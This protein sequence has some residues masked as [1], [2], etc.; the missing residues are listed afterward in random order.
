MKKLTIAL[1]GYFWDK[2]TV[3]VGQ[4]LHGLVAALAQEPAVELRI[5]VPGDTA[6]PPPPAGVTVS[7]LRV[8]F[9]GRPN[10]AKLAFEQYAVPIAAQLD[11]VDLLHVPYFA[12]PYASRT[13]VVCTI[14]DLI[15]LTRPAYRGGLLVR[16]Y[17]SLV[18]RA[19]RRCRRLI[20]ISAA[21]KATTI[22]TLPRTAADIDVTYLA[23]D[24]R[25]TPRGD[26]AAIRQRLALPAHYIYYVGGY[27]ERKNIPTL[28]HAYAA[29]PAAL[30]SAYPLVLAGRAAG[31]N[32]LLFPDIDALISASGVTAD[33]RRIDVTRDEN[34]ALYRGATL[35]VYPSCDEGFG[36]P[37]LEAMACGTPVVCADAASIPEV[38]GTAARVVAPRDTAAWTRALAELL[39][40][41]PARAAYRSAGL[42]RA[43]AFS[44]EKTAT[45]TLACYRHA[46]GDEV[47]A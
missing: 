32:P 3:G 13:P 17:T 10:L 33:I 40:D 37:P 20:A 30:R 1:N 9:T 4:Y 36:L 15:P 46:L 43:G 11:R 18:Q 29:L 5:Y 19:A 42:A 41:E 39:A 34:P 38:V 35:F 47:P 7:R 25:Y 24:P 22:A 6:P 16:T 26:D 44:Y 12:P 31:S 23:A 27:D 28:I 45:A 8:P 2:P 14:P 21:V